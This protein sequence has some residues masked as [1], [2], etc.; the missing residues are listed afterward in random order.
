M[1]RSSSDLE[2]P[3]LSKNDAAIII[4]AVE[5]AVDFPRIR[6]EARENEFTQIVPYDDGTD[7]ERWDGLS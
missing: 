6:H 2:V 7:A 5:I 4:A 1:H 3:P